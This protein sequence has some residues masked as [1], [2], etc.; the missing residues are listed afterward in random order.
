MQARSISEN[1][2]PATAATLANA[3]APLAEAQFRWE[4]HIFSNQMPL[5][6]SSERIAETLRPTIVPQY[7]LLGRPPQGRCRPK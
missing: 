6:D 7:R 5:A 4:K 2:S 3:E 1:P